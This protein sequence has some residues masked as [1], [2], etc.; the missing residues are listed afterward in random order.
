[1]SRPCLICRHPN[2]A[3]IDAAVI[4]KISY[5]EIVLNYRVSKSGLTRHKAHL[6]A[7][8]SN[9]VRQQEK[10]GERYGEN[11]LAQVED[12]RQRTMTILDEVKAG[13]SYAVALQA[14]REARACLELLGRIS[15]KLQPGT[16]VNVA[17]YNTPE[18]G[19]LMY[20]VINGLKD[21]PEARER[22][23]QILGGQTFPQL[24]LPT[25]LQDSDVIVQE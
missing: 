11:L 18:W 13:G 6:T 3:E 25:P 20:K 19:R 2:R 22:L 16:N 12:L 24:T 4:A 1:M 15:G 5:S 9:V 8:L 17:I 14:V 10:A 21:F 23:I 7:Q